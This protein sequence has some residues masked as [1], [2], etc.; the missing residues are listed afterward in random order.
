MGGGEALIAS[1][2]IAFIFG[3][4]VLFAYLVLHYGNKNKNKKMDT[5]LK[6]VEQGGDVNPEL[7][8]MLETPDG[9]TSDLRKG[10]VWLAIGIPLTLAMMLNNIGDDWAT[11]FFGLIPVFIGIGY[12]IVMKYGHKTEK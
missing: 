5:L 6:I 3:G 8:G 11:G 1:I 12:L 2:S 4:P 9:P 10:V 7:M